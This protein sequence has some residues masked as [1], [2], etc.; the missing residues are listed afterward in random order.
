MKTRTRHAK[1]LLALICLFVESG[2]L[3]AQVL[4]DQFGGDQAGIQLEFG[5][6]TVGELIELLREKAPDLSILITSE[7]S[8]SHLEPFKL[9][10]AHPV[11]LFN[12]LERLEPELR[13]EHISVN[14]GRITLPRTL[15]VES[16][17]HLI[18]SEKQDGRGDGRVTM[19]DL[20]AAIQTA[21]AFVSSAHPATIKVHAETGL[22]IVSGSSAQVK[23]VSQVVSK[24]RSAMTRGQSTTTRISQYQDSHGRALTATELQDVVQTLTLE[25]AHKTLLL[26][27]YEEELRIKTETGSDPKQRDGY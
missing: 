7:A 23:T 22:L 26:R 9:E 20:L 6:G 17:S 3:R 18:V 19:Q 11:L 25:I 27:A 10:N 4:G 14:L 21:L 1:V 12:I 16:I 13:V 24:L 2:T 8:K 5:G 15:G